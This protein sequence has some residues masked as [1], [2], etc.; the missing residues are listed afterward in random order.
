MSISKKNKI[1]AIVGTTASGK[2]TLGVHL[3]LKFGGEIVSADSRQ[4]YR[5]MDIGTGKDLDEYKIK[6][7]SKTIQIPYHLID[8]VDP[9]DEFSLAQ[10]LE[11]AHKAIGDILS[12][13]KLPIVVGGTGLWTQALTEGYNL[14]EVKPDKAKRK[15]LE[16][17]SAAELF[18][19]LQ[20]KNPKFAQKLNLSDKQNKRRLIRYLEILDTDSDFTYPASREPIYGSLILGLTYPRPELKK[21]IYKRLIERLEKQDMVDE[22]ERL[23]AQGVSWQRLK[24]FGLEYKWITFYLT[25]EIDYETMVEKL[26]QAIANFAKRQMT[27]L[28]RWERQGAQIHWIKDKKQAEKLV[29]N[30]LDKK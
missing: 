22:V 13:R 29:K 4:V 17:L 8:V 19:K 6:K 1:V 5:G 27:W 11:L 2:T 14:P 20:A 3:A 26:N 9:Q 30:F 10:F 12:R 21:R 24:N 7:G 28:R 15:R 25:G 16:K 23:H 18:E